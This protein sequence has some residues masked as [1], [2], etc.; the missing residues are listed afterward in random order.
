MFSLCDMANIYAK[1]TKLKVI[2]AIHHIKRLK[3]LKRMLNECDL[4][5]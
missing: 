3:W 4:N 5:K 1:S 2:N